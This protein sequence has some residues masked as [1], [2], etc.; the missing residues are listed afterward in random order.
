MMKKLVMWDGD[1]TLWNGTLM[2]GDVGE[3]GTD[4][5]WQVETLRERGV[6]Q[7]MAS[8]NLQAD[9][10]RTL[11]R[12]GLDAAFVDIQADLNRT[13]PE[14]VRA[15]MER[16]GI[17]KPEDVVFIDDQGFNRA[18]VEHALAGVMT[19]P[20]EHVS[21]MIQDY[22]TKAHY[23]AED[24][25]RVRKYK[26]EAIREQAQA[27]YTGNRQDFLRSCQLRMTVRKAQAADYARLSDLA[28]RANQF[29][30]A[31]PS[32][33]PLS[34]AMARQRV[35]VA[36][37]ADTFGDYGLSALAMVHP[38]GKIQLFV[39]S[40]RLQGKGIGSAFL[41]WLI[42][43]LNVNSA[44][45]QET[46]YNGGVRALYTWYGFGIEESRTKLVLAS[47]PLGK[48]VVIPNWVQVVEV[49]E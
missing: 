25:D 9:V 8:R 2:E 12:Y 6:L 40:C 19:L 22:C 47:R 15:T 31:D 11:H 44:Q 3:V 23:T 48:R 14:M 13:K 1:E 28:E 43:H 27:A 20:P 36:S 34:I 18:E 16:L 37:V 10:E 17:V 4:R 24:R 26:A 42:N 7:A 45:W 30:A 29:S 33:L 46:E 21:D 41:G 35:W 32:M 5:L 49:P 38:G 39:V